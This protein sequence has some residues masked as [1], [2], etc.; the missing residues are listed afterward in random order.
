M[1]ND[2]DIEKMSNKNKILQILT[3][4]FLSLALVSCISNMIYTIIT[5]NLKDNL[6]S[7]ILVI[8]LAIFSIVYLIIGI[9]LRK[10]IH[11]ILIIIGSIFIT[12]F[13]LFNIITSIN[14]KDYVIDFTDM[15]IKDVVSWADERNILIEQEFKNSDTV[16]QYHVISQDIKAG[17]STKNVKTIKVVISD[18]VDTNITTVVDNMIGWDLDKVIEYIDENHL[19]NVNITFEFSDTYKKDTI[20][21]QDVIKEIK[22]NEEVNLVSSLGKKS[23]LKSVTLDNLVGMDLFHAKVYCGRNY[24]NYSIEYTYSEDSEDIVLSQS[25][26][27]WEVISPSDNKELVLTVSKKD[28]ITIPDL[29]KMTM[30]EIT[31]WA[32]NNRLKVEFTEEYDDTIKKDKVI[33]SNYIKGNTVDIDTTIN[34][35]I[36]KGALYM[37]EFTNVN[38]FIEWANEYEVNYNI[39]YKYSTSV[40]QGNIIS[41]SHKK[42]QIIKNSDTIEVIASQG[43]STTIPNLIGLTKTEAEKA[44]SSANIKCSFTSSDSSYNIVIKQSMKSG[45]TVPVNTAVTVT[46]GS[47]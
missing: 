9:H 45:S 15:D 36:S 2:F 7:I 5:S 22:R 34:V 4:F 26:K 18:G 14:T 17:I 28:K 12:G 38:D 8:L 23:E 11:K 41:I 30:S 16:T 6:I 10:N 39:E 40:N 37:S 32:T 20:M 29:T 33:S 24:I 25:I 47:N 43:G 46:L 13:S 27:K 21:S 3:Y 44:C 19:T 31:T 1:E 42:G 35:V